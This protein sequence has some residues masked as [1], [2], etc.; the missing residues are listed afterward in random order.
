MIIRHSLFFCREERTFVMNHYTMKHLPD[1]ERPYE[2]CLNAGPA[3]L[4][5]AELLAVI[6]RTGTKGTTSV[7]LAKEIL[8]RST[9]KPGLLGLHHLSTSELRSIKGVGMVKAVQLQCIAELSRRIAKAAAGGGHIFTSAKAIADYYME[10]FRH[11]CQEQV[12]LLC[13][14][15]K[16]ELLSEKMISKG[17]VSQACVSPREVFLEALKCQAVYVILLHNHP[18]GDVSP[19]PEDRLLTMRVHESGNLIGISLMD[20]IIL[21]NRCYFS[22]REE[23]IIK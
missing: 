2:K 6:L 9:V 21:G 4:T 11:L 15:T 12:F 13:F 3:V 18:S 22:F 8:N 14:D 17:T 7:G 16:G 1:D 23:G 20:H 19:S 10:D 5:D